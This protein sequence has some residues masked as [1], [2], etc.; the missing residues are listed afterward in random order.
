MKTNVS[1]KANAII[2]VLN[3]P[4]F[5]SGFLLTAMLYEANKIPTLSAEN[6]IGNIEKLK[7]IILKAFI[8]INRGRSPDLVTLKKLPFVFI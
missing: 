7:T 4:S 6:A 2:V 5:S 3:K 8:I 1:T